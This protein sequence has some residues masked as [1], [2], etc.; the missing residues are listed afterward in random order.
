MATSHQ[1][2]V[3]WKRLGVDKQQTDN[4]LTV[5][6]RA[7]TIRERR[8][9]SSATPP[10][11]T[12]PEPQSRA[13]LSPLTPVSLYSASVSFHPYRHSFL[14][15]FLSFLPP[16]LLDSTLI[17]ASFR[18]CAAFALPLTGR[19]AV[20]DTYPA[21]SSSAGSMDCGTL[22]GETHNTPSPPLFFSCV[23]VCDCSSCRPYRSDSGTDVNSFTV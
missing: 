11:P 19:A 10:P 6:G 20:H 7:Q 14:P 23:Y 5:N 21:E 1:T 18:P 17:C 13:T 8:K 12:R 4:F 2:P 3:R 16:P 15:S 22:R 9:P